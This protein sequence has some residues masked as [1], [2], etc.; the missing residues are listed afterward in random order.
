MRAFQ[1]LNPSTSL[2]DCA[3]ISSMDKEDCEYVR[4]LIPIMGERLWSAKNFLNLEATALPGR[5]PAFLSEHFMNQHEVLALNAFFAGEAMEFAVCLEHL[6][7]KLLQG[8]EPTATAR[9][10]RQALLFIS[11]V[12]NTNIASFKYNKYKVRYTSYI[13]T[14]FI[15]ATRRV[16]E[17]RST[18]TKYCI[19]PGL[20]SSILDFILWRTTGHVSYGHKTTF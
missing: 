3:E 2:A 15:E 10:W 12:Y 17:T 9:R 13:Y 6:C 20:D 14:P 4:K 18:S 5:R 8:E 1:V 11:C 7:G 16:T 19:F